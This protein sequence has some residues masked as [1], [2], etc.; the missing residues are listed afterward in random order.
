MIAH[1][2]IARRQADVIV[3]LNQNGTR[4]TIRDGKYGRVLAENVDVYVMGHFIESAGKTRSI[5]CDTSDTWLAGDIG[6]LDA[7]L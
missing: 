1:V 4:F 2:E 5:Y 3:S 7:A 6:K